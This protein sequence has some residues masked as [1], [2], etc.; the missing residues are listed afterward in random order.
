MKHLFLILFLTSFLFQLSAQNSFEEGYFIKND[1]TRI[2]CLIKNEKWN[3][4]PSSFKYKLDK[5]KSSN[6][7][8]IENTKEVGINERYKF[9]RATVNVDHTLD[10]VNELK[11]GAKPNFKEETI[12][13]NVLVEGQANLYSYYTNNFRRYFYN[14][15]S[16]NIEPLIYKEYLNANQQIAF[17]REFRTQLWNNLKCESIA[18]DKIQELKYTKNA[19]GSFFIE[20]NT[21]NAAQVSN[22]LKLRKSSNNLNLKL[23]LGVLLSEVNIDSYNNYPSDITNKY[24][25]FRYGIEGEYFLPVKDRRLSLSTEVSYNKY[26]ILGE[27]EYQPFI[28]SSTQDT[29]YR[30]RQ[31]D[32]KYQFLEVPLNLRYYHT[33]NSQN[34]L[35]FTT[36]FVFEVDIKSVFSDGGA[37]EDF[38]R[39]NNGFGVGVG[40]TYNNKVSIEYKY[41]FIRISDPL[42]GVSA[43]VNYKSNFITI[44]YN[45]IK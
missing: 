27:V 22:Y 42:Y 19:L 33:I 34:K 32:L 30:E 6:T 11:T 2:S 40:Y 35:F 9:I 37:I 17:N 43:S 20:Y 1:G 28:S 45:F 16:E 36:S 14:K 24:T 12:F 23:R 10:D 31:F 5:E 18:F 13:L 3:F 7:L 25:R 21:C 8:T 38:I 44:G 39:S 15:N 29:L 41:N 4:N 26:T